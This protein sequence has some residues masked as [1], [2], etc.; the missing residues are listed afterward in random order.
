MTYALCSTSPFFFI[1][2]CDLLLQ[3][4]ARQVVRDKETSDWWQQS[5]DSAALSLRQVC[6]HPALPFTQYVGR[7]SG[8]KI[9][10]PFMVDGPGEPD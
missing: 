10:G 1:T 2:I 7:A 4:G 5:F 6:C 9:D 3:V 8:L